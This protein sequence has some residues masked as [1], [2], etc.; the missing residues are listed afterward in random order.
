[1]TFSFSRVNCYHQCPYQFYCHY[2]EKEDGLDNF[3]AQSGGFVHRLLEGIL[4]KEITVDEAIVRF[5]RDFEDECDAPVSQ[6]IKDTTFEK[7][8]EFLTSYDEDKIKKYKILGVEEEV[9]FDIDGYSFRGFIDL[10]IE[11]DRGEIIV[12][13]HK[14]AAYPLGKNGKVLKNQLSAFEEHKRQLYLYSKAVLGKY[15]KFPSY[16]G[17]NHFKDNK[18][19]LIAFDEEEYFN[20]LLWAKL[21]I[22][23]IKSDDVFAPK[24]DYFFCKNLCEYREDCVYIDDDNEEEDE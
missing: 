11:N 3:W 10:L 4:K 18:T 1:M 21:S 6:K 24:K 12:I 22:E 5:V 19:C 15:G 2:I 13:D 20:S 17:W 14:S 8:C 9:R 7:I 16:L 23:S